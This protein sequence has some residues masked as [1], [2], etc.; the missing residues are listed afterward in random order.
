MFGLTPF[1]RHAVRR[2]NDQDHFFNLMDDF[3]LVRNLRND[4]FKLDIKEE[5][6]AYIIEADLPGVKNEEIQLSYQD[7]H[8]SIEIEKDETMQ[9]EKRNYIHRERRQCSMKRTLNLGDLNMD[10]I[11]A[12]LK[13]GILIIKAPKAAVIENKKRIEIK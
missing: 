5:D 6:N 7:G 2:T 3:F 10:Q 12:N 13:D 1:N 9:E 4:A 8:L 11:E